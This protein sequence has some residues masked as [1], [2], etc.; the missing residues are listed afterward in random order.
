MSI[1]AQLISKYNTDLMSMEKVRSLM[2]AVP[3]DAQEEAIDLELAQEAMPSEIAKM[4]GVSALGAERR[5]II[6][7]LNT[8]Y[9]SDQQEAFP[10]AWWWEMHT[11]ICK[12]LVVSMCLEGANL[13]SFGVEKVECS[14]IPQCLLYLHQK[15]SHEEADFEALS[16]R[17]KT[18]GTAM[19]KD[20][21]LYMKL[22]LA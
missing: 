6:A 21:P 13:R 8:V 5:A 22:Y 1:C 4:G 18:L 2:R 19:Q 12:L 16:L 10:S 20:H 14:D 3:Q 15:I 9:F 17:Y 7:W 11:R